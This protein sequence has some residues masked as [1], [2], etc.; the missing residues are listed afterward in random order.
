MLPPGAFSGCLR[1]CVIHALDTRYASPLSGTTWLA[2]RMAT[3]CVAIA[4]LSASFA[5]CSITQSSHSLR[6]DRSGPPPKRACNI[7]HASREMRFIMGSIDGPTPPWVQHSTSLA[8][9]MPLSSSSGF[10]SQRANHC[11]EIQR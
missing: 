6:A 4:D 10:L 11:V 3:M 5:Q 9:P 1:H 2:C 8:M 7:F